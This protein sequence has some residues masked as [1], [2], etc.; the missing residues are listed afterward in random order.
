MV[1]HCI[2]HCATSP[3]GGV[4]VVRVLTTYHMLG[5]LFWE[6]VSRGLYCVDVIGVRVSRFL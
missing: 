3:L 1:S 4:D 5:L 2:N 6:C